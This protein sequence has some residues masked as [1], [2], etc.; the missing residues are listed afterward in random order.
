MI[1]DAHTHLFPPEVCARRER[2]FDGEPNFRLLYEDPRA[3]LLGAEELVAALESWGADAA[4]AFAFPWNSPAA[5]TLCNDYALDAARRFPDRIIP[6][7]CVHPLAPGALREAERC[8]AAGA[9]GLGEI[10]TYGEGLGPEVRARIAPLAELCRE[11][12]VPLLLHAN[13]P[14]GHAYPGKSRMEP[15]ELYTLIAAHPKT[16][17]ILAHFG[18]GL[19]FW[20]LLKKE[21]DEALANVY[22]DTAAAPYLFKP[23]IYRRFCEIAG[24]GRL[25]YGSDFPLL[26]LPR[27]EKDFTLG[28]LSEE[29]KAAIL[30]GNLARLLGKA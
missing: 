16:T 5:A 7:A 11:A 30:G 13:E 22:Y 28:A 3:Q 24:V 26:E 9:R 14:V 19:F 1:L 10:A 18:G 12:N 25:L 21:A 27:Y 4:V 23:E 17:W 15:S 20:H 6:F 8:L 29:E 2:F